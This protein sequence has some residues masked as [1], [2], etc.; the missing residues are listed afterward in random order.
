MNNDIKIDIRPLGDSALTLQIGQNINPLVHQKLSQITQYIEKEP[1][2]GFIEVV[3][4]YN[5]LTVYYNPIDV[6]VFYNLENMT[7]FAKVR[8]IIQGYMKS[9]DHI[10]EPKS[11]IIRIPVVYGGDFG[12]DLE[13]VAHFNQLSVDEVIDIHS[14]A[15]YLVYMIGFA[16]GFPFLGGMDDLIATP[17]KSSPRP[18]ILNNSIGIAGK[19]TGIYSLETPGGWQIIGRTPLD[20]YLPNQHP[21]SLLQSGDY[22]RFVP[23]SLSKYEKLRGRQHVH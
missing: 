9:S 20:L 5:S 15:D 1:F 7:A 23:I 3:P 10:A 21:P 19:Q 17:R 6:H 8:N 2:E 11:R 12:P 16:P 4:S 14:R 22:V 18:V 13:Y